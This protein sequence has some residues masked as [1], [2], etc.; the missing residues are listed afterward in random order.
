MAK[1]DK[2]KRGPEVAMSEDER[3]RIERAARLEGRSIASFLRYYG[4]RAAHAALASHS[5]PPTETAA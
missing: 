1:P 2:L 4:A 3:D 5:E